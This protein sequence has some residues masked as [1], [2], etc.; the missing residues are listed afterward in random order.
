MSRLEVFES[1]FLYQDKKFIS[2]SLNVKTETE[3]L[4]ASFQLRVGLVVLTDYNVQQLLP[5]PI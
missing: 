5:V 1:Q 4:Q 2:L 3:F